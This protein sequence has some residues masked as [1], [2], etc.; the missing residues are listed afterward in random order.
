[1]ISISSLDCSQNFIALH[2]Q[3]VRIIIYNALNDDRD[4]TFPSYTRRAHSQGDIRASARLPYPGRDNSARFQCRGI[5]NVARIAHT[6][7]DMRNRRVSLADS[8]SNPNILLDVTRF[9]R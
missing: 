7:F 3:N 8:P 5:C 6:V 9:F 2:L 1:M 4:L